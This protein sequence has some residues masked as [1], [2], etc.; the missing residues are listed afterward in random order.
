MA[1][2]T[3]FTSEET[4]RSLQRLETAVGQFASIKSQVGALTEATDRKLQ[5]I[6]ASTP[7][8]SKSATT[9]LR[10][11]RVGV[12]YDSANTIASQRSAVLAK[13]LQQSGAL[14]DVRM[15]PT[16]AA[17]I[18]RLGVV[19][20]VEVRHNDDEQQVAQELQAL[21]NGVDGTLA[22]KLVRVSTPTYQFV[23]IFVN[24]APQ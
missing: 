22:P 7:A 13:N 5:A 2:E 6:Q 11:F 17:F 18:K 23:S 3:P 9:D 19:T 4:L 21:I 20:G 1:T 16:T 10:Q 15:Y 14:T 8:A 12:Y 24:L